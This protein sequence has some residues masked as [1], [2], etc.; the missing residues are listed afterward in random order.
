MTWVGDITQ[1]LTAYISDRE[2]DMSLDAFFDNYA[3]REQ[4]NGNIDAYALYY[5]RCHCKEPLSHRLR[6]YYQSNLNQ[7][8]KYFTR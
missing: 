2:T 5:Q 6:L 1:S 4:L 8:F 7:R 3:T